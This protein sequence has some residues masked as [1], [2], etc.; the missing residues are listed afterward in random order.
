[1]TNT[2]EI[3]INPTLSV[4]ETQLI[5]LALSRCYSDA[6]REARD[7]KDLDGKYAAE[8]VAKEYRAISD[9][10]QA[11]LVSELEKRKKI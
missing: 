7:I 5:R 8:K 3:T 11:M 1:M 10:L 6:M 9:K 2:N 4:Y